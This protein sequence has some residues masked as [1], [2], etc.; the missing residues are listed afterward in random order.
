MIKKKKRKESIKT[1]IKKDFRTRKF[2]WGIIFAKDISF[3]LGTKVN[4]VSS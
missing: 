1:E 4:F 2:I 3:S